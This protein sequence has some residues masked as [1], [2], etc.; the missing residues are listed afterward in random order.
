MK[1][2]FIKGLGLLACVAVQ[3][4]ALAAPSDVNV[5][6]IKNL[7]AGIHGMAVAD[8]GDLYVSDSFGN[9]QSTRRVYR[10]PAPYTGSLQSTPITGALPA[11]LLWDNNTLYVADTSNNTIRQFDSNFNLINSWSVSAPWLIKKASDGALLITSYNNQVYRLTSG[12][13][14]SLV[15][16]N[17]AA[18]FGIEQA[19]DNSIWVSE[20]GAA[21]GDPGYLRRWSMSGT[22][23]EQVSYNWDNPEGLQLDNEGSLWIADTGAGEILR[24]SDEGQLD[25]ISAGLSF[26]IIITEMPD[27]DLL[28][29]TSGGAP[30]LYKI[31]FQEPAT[32]TPVQ[33]QAVIQATVNGTT[34]DFSSQGSTGCNLTYQ[35]SFGDGNS[36]TSASPSHTYGADGTYTV[37]LTVTT[38]TGQTDSSS[39][40]VSVAAPQSSL[41][42]DEQNLSAGRN[43]ELH[44][45]F[46]VPTGSSQL[47]VN[48]SG[49]TGDADLYVRYGA[50]ASRRSYDCR[51]YLDGNN[52]S[53]TFNNPQAGTWHVMSRAYRPF[54][55]LNLSAEVK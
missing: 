1:S 22:M 47:I 37:N 5:T 18:P 50:K 42:L 49:G 28:F 2:Q 51:P 3:S 13:S 19:T 33:P 54:S 4:A 16:G 14:L 39:Q 29:N 52:E 23:L 55:D 43:A 41:L 48:Q 40:Q 11:G 15:V 46:S 31:D 7:P 17:L 53:C 36:A 30:G 10:L 45:N 35:W 34:V 24:L 38:E 20:Q 32:C 9:Y 26:P 8:N 25:L 12:G 6:L 27:G 21:A 44:F